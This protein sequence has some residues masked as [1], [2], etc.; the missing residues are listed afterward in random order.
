MQN[1]I[2]IL[3]SEDSEGIK[4][5]LN[6]KFR[7]LSGIPADKEKDLLGMGRKAY[8]GKPSLK[9]KE[10]KEEKTKKVRYV[11]EVNG[12]K[13]EEFLEEKVDVITGYT[14]KDDLDLKVFYSTETFEDQLL[15]EG[16][17]EITLDDSVKGYSYTLNDDGNAES[18]SLDEIKNHEIYREIAILKAV[19]VEVE[20][21]GGDTL[22]VDSLISAELAKL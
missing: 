7:I 5:V 17:E 14:T 4:T 11:N 15:G 22:Y 1:L 18:E 6:W 8:Y 2:K 3:Y 13:E 19:K 16:I 9:L 10:V 12:K 21:I 20:L